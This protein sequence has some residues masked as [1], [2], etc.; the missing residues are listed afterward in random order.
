MAI[1]KMKMMNLAF[2]KKDAHQVLQEI[3]LDGSLHISN[4][5]NT[6]NF[7]MR[8]MDSQKQSFDKMGVDIN[9]ISPYSSDKVFRKKQYKEILDKMFNFLDIDEEQLQLEK[10]KYLDYTEKLKVLDELSKNAEEIKNREDSNRYQRSKTKILLKAVEYFEDSDFEISKFTNLKNV[11]VY[12][13]EIV[14]GS[15]IKLKENYENTKILVVHL[16][17]NEYG[18]SV[19][20]FTPKVYESD[21]KYFLNSLSFNNI[22]LPNVNFSFK[23]L[24]KAKKNELKDLEKEQK[25]I[26]EEKQ[27]F[28]NTYMQEILSLYYRY[29]IIEKIEELESHAVMSQ[30][31]VILSGFV[32]E[33]KISNLK[34]MIEKV[35]DDV[36]IDFSEDTKIPSIFKIPTKLKNNFILKPFETLVKMY[37]IPNYE[38]VDPTPF[39]AITYML[40]FGMMFGDVGQGL[41]F[42]LVGYMLSSKLGSLSKIIQRIGVS[43][44]VFGF[45][46]GSVFG[47]ENV[48]PALIIRPMEDI[49][50][51]LIA[52]IV[53]GVILVTIAYFIGFYNLNLRKEYA[54]LYFDK[55]GISGF[56][57]Y[58][59]FLLFL[60]NIAYFSSKIDTNV[61]SMLTILSIAVMIITSCLM[62]FKP[63]LAE[64][65]EKNSH[66]KEEFSPVEGGFEMFET[67]MGFFS[68]TLS[69]IRVGAFAI[70][71][72]G[73]FMAFHALG[74]MIGN[75]F[76]NI[77]MI[78]IGN[79]VIL[80]LEGLIVFIQAIRL[81]Y[82]ELFSKY[83]TGEGIDYNPLHVEINKH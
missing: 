49:N 61:S 56:I 53:V 27:T 1:E 37:S 74:H 36:L 6:S 23:D 35:S 81:Q 67:V 15:W 71:H 64:K 54:K 46:Y 50:N 10:L 59:G 31:F 77:L 5:S 38:E 69:F 52:S 4:S 19:M 22:E 70:N 26:E 20:I 73:L 28:K 66:K 79:I 21:M 43:S 41:V 48:I 68:N 62:F 65:F 44:I 72:V 75:S 51:I 55:N 47:L 25:L 30:S 58:L 29:K 13:G 3:V 57:F 9:K 24:I 78:V 39:F 33:S 11:K 83:F 8:Y 7:T 17:S 2:L 14:K 60:I 76:G 40:L 32:P 63:K 12:I 18:E 82:Y 16:G 45:L 42:V 34:N 80:V